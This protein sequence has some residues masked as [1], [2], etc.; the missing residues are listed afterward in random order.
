MV[1]IN[2]SSTSYPRFE[3]GDEER[4]RR[5]AGKIPTYPFKFKLKITTT[6]F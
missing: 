2:N 3:T 1:K 6:L 4:L 5:T